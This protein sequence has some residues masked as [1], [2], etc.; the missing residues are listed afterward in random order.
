M[1]YV[2]LD[3]MDLEQSAK[4]GSLDLLCYRE[5]RGGPGGTRST[6]FVSRGFRVANRGGHT[7]PF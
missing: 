7:Y 5:D 3:A 4:L 1:I 6:P 2:L